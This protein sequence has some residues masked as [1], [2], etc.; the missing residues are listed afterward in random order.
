MKYNSMTSLERTIDFLNGGGEIIAFYHSTDFITIFKLTEPPFLY[1][2]IH[3]IFDINI[4]MSIFFYFLK[5]EFEQIDRFFD[6]RGRDSCA[7]PIL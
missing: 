2:F 1:L 6:W 4:R 3:H 7:L 5:Y